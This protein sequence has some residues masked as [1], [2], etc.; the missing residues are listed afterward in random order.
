[1][2]FVE[3][4]TTFLGGVGGTVVL[5]MPGYI[6]SRALRRGV[7]VPDATDL[8]FVATTA[9]GGLITH[10][11]FLPWTLALAREITLVFNTWADKLNAINAS[12]AK[13]EISR[14]ALPDLP[15]AE[16]ALW[17][18]IVLIV[19][20]AILGS[21][22]AFAAARF[23][24]PWQ[25]ITDRLGLTP[26]LRPERAWTWTFSKLYDANLGAWVRVRMKDEDK[27]YI[28]Q[29]G[30]QSMASSDP[31]NPDIYFQSFIVADA[32]GKPV[33]EVAAPNKGLWIAGGEIVSLEFF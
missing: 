21:A 14:V 27:V 29:F 26:S 15:Y 3:G 10:I 6:L 16:I 24:G 5:L 22:I 32:T 28:G 9:I 25:G 2:D 1:V 8:I 18:F 30:D 20:P 19:A 23:S 11:L 7:R 12:V 31:A 4:L 33:S 17:T 13:G